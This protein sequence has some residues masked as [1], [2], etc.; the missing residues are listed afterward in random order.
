MIVLLF[1]LFLQIRE[2][3][4]E[5]LHG[6]AATPRLTARALKPAAVSAYFRAGYDKA[7]G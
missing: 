5:E 4:D 1:L 6:N 3:G 7:R 2:R